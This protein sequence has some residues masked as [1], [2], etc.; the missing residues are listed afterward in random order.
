[1]RIPCGMH[2]ECENYKHDACEG[3]GV[4]TRIPPATLYAM[5]EADKLLKKLGMYDTSNTSKTGEEE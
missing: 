4:L 3:C 5:K 2:H 1:M